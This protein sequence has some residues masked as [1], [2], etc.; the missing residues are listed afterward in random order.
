MRRKS[1]LIPKLHV[2]KGDNVKVIAGDDR[3][4]TG[5]IIEIF[6]EKR[7]AKV[8]GLNIVTK[9][10][11]PTA[12]NPDGGRIKMEASINLSNLML[13]DPKSGQPTRVGRKKNAE[14]NLVRISVKSK[15]EIK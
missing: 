11:K 4:K 15:E 9:H 7:K 6:P 3:G 2:K 1:N 5:R 14:G 12:A 13:I 10:S 8:E